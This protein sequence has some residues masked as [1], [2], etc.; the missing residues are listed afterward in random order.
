[1][2]TSSP[3]TKT[4]SQAAP[5]LALTAALLATCFAVLT[6]DVVDHSG[7]TV[8]DPEIAARAID[9]RTQV[10]TALAHFVSAI[11]DTLSMSILAAVV[12]LGLLRAGDRA[13][14]TL[15]AVAGLG[16]A[17]IVLGGKRVIGR[18]RPPVIDRLATEHTLSY[19]SGH[20][21]GSCVVIG[22]CAVVLIPKL[23]RQA[24]RIVTAALAV[25]FVVA[26]GCSRVYL[27][28][29]W[30]TDVLGAWC[31]SLAWISL[32]LAVFHYRRRTLADTADAAATD[33]DTR[34]PG[35]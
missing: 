30:A 18:E 19:P 22:I 14:A 32:C 9:L 3:T 35:E 29:H 27:G 2:T 10:L 21:V 7:L 6:H 15:V 1:M 23:H 17:V 28:V 8:I 16:A 26:V 33:T 24:A 12:C 11:G 4:R 5:A 13:H 25:L 34:T 31:I 20:S